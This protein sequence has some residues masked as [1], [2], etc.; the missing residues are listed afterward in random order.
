MVGV[1]RKRTNEKSDLSKALKDFIDYAE[2][3]LTWFSFNFVL[4]MMP[5]F[6]MYILDSNSLR[7]EG[8]DSSFVPIMYTLW[9]MH[10]IHFALL[11]R[12][13]TFKDEVSKDK[14]KDEKD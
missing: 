3:N 7:I 14:A 5:P 1:C 10:S 9:G 4:C 13:Y 12:I 11:P 2:L 8:R 6:C